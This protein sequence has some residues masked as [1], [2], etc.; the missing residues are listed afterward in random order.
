MDE[1]VF[2][3]CSAELM[4]GDVQAF[5]EQNKVRYLDVLRHDESETHIS[6]L[7]VHLS[8]APATSGGASCRSNRP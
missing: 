2:E 8:N 3:C 7:P 1:V 4:I 6:R 5:A